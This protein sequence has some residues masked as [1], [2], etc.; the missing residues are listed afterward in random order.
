MQN[1]PIT[2]DFSL[3]SELVPKKTPEIARNLVL[4]K[5]NNELRFQ[6]EIYMRYG[7]NFEDKVLDSISVIIDNYD[8]DSRDDKFLKFVKQFIQYPL[9]DSYISRINRR[10]DDI[11]VDFE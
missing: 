9:Y 8:G 2:R 11:L 4:R 1:I 6:A 3:A 7:Q 5:F 10:F